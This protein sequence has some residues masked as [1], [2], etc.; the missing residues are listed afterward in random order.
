MSTDINLDD[1]SWLRK[2]SGL[3]TEAVEYYKEQDAHNG[4]LMIR[5]PNEDAFNIYLP[6]VAP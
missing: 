4:A 6:K 3:D 5:L 1:W 2:I